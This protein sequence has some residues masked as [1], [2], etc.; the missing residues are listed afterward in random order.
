[1]NST[2]IDFSAQFGGRDAASAGLPHFKSLKAAA[3]GLSFEGFPF[4]KLAFILR[5][6]G[7]VTRYGISGAGNLDVAENGDYLSIDVGITQHDWDQIGDTITSAILSSGDQLRQVAEN[8]S[9][10]FDFRELQSCL[11][12]LIDRYKRELASRRM[13]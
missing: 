3:R 5:I 10:A 1:M 8:D 4:P 12:D 9:W 2:S 13:S 7:E 6:D 11:T